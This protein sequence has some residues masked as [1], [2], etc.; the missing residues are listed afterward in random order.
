[1]L[2]AYLK[3]HRKTI[4]VLVISCT[5]AALIFALYR[6]PVQAVLYTAAVCLLFEAVVL[7]LDYGRFCLKH[8]GL[9]QCLRE[10][11]EDDGDAGDREGPGWEGGVSDRPG[12]AASAAVRKSGS[13]QRPDPGAVLEHLPQP[14]GIL[15]EDYQALLLTLEKERRELQDEMEQRYRDMVDYYTVWAHQIKTPI[16][17]MRLLLQ[18]E[19]PLDE[20]GA[21]PGNRKMRMPGRAADGKE[22]ELREQASDGMKAGAPGQMS[23]STGTG[24]SEQAPDDIE[25][26]LPEQASDDTW[27]DL[28]ES[29]GAAVRTDG[30]RR[31]LQEE[32]RRVEQYVE[33]VLCYLR[34]DS[35]STDYVFREYDLDD[36]VR[37]AVRRYASTFIQKK[38]RLEYEPLQARVVTDEKWLLFVIEQVLSNALKYTAEG[39]IAISLEPP[40][41]L[42]IRDTGIGI[43][44]EDLPRI[45]EKGYTGGNGRGDKRASGIGMYL[46]SRI[47]ANLGHDIWVTSEP[48]RGTEVRIDLKNAE[49]EIE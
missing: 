16:A 12:H 1:M 15:E 36:I 13:L 5:A 30:S 19:P 35:N 48:G 7:G 42:C 41:T 11:G 23:D 9:E 49:L 21:L 2:R 3:L 29:E 27:T 17:A 4:A 20:E 6:L 28:P 8:R 10:L 22:A 47:C 34:L 25:T 46:C 18:E 45:F 24:M 38:L 33:M 32:L 40:K 43:A 26:D 44:P 37:Q 31:E 39:V 14:S